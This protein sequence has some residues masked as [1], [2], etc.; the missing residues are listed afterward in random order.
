MDQ[1]LSLVPVQAKSQMEQLL[2]TSK[3]SIKI[4]KK[5]QTKHGDFRK[6]RNGSSIITLN[7]TSNPYRFLITLLH[8]LAHFKVSQSV[9]YRTKPHCKEWKNAYRETLLPFL[10]PE[11]VPEH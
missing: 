5:R 1:V 11:I 8:E 9:Q 6:Q 4:T 7:T 3:D 2:K 10:N